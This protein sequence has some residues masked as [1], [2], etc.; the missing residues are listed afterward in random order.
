MKEDKT[1]GLIINDFQIDNQKTYAIKVIDNDIFPE[2]YINYYNELSNNGVKI[3]IAYKNKL[4]LLRDFEY[5]IKNY[6]LK[7]KLD[8]INEELLDNNFKQFKKTNIYILNS[9]YLI[10]ADNYKQY[11]K[12]EKKFN[13]AIENDKYI[14]MQYA[15]LKHQSVIEKAIKR[16]ILNKE[17]IIQISD[18]IKIPID[19]RF[20]FEITD[21]YIRTLPDIYD[22]ANNTYYEI[23]VK[24]MGK[25]NMAIELSQ[26]F[27]NY[28]MTK[29]KIKMF[30]I[31]YDENTQ[32]LLLL[33]PENLLSKVKYVAL[34]INK[35]LVE[36]YYKKV[37]LMMFSYNLAN[38]V[39]N[40]KVKMVEPHKSIF[41]SNYPYCVINI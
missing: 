21:I 18:Y 16:G 14:A 8:E 29:N 11:E 20:N 4:I 27:F 32:K 24:K 12:I 41:I 6:G 40:L 31:I 35:N 25:K 5:F 17:N 28:V 22:T 7:I 9:S 26:L 37:N 30:Y 15:S 1:N 3:K 34:P 38:N 2:N 39:L 10:I 33:K 36:K 13:T 23:K 19:I